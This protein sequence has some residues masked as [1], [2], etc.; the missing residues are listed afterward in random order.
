MNKVNTGTKFNSIT[1]KITNNVKIETIR[2]H[3]YIVIVMIIIIVG[4]IAYGLYYY[5]SNKI[6]YAYKSN[7]SYY[8]DNL[9]DYEPIFHY[10][11][12]NL[13]EC[14]NR[15]EQDILCTGITYNN[16]TQE[17]IGTAGIGVVRQEDA[18]LT[19]WVKQSTNLNVN[20]DFTKSIVLG[21]TDGPEIIPAKNITQPHIAGSFCLSFNLCIRDYHHNYGHWR[22]IL[23]KGTPPSQSNAYD[24]NTWERLVRDIPKQFIGIWLAPFNNNIRIAIS[25]VVISQTAKNY[26]D[27]ANVQ[28]CNFDSCYISDV[29]KISNADTVL[30]AVPQKIIKNI[31]FIEH[32]ISSVPLNREAN[33]II[34]VFSNNIELYQDGKLVKTAVLEGA[35]EFNSENMFVMQPNSINGYISNVIYYPAYLTLVDIS[36]IQNIPASSNTSNTSS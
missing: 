18:K 13:A 30:S 26:Y 15:C 3:P 14:V 23:H 21:W 19:S 10:N 17:C 32:D 35:P 33:Y 31:E 24:Y 16:E 36:K 20:N 2:D 7:S 6:D 34:N 22:H 8:G 9:L 27:H 12:N 5:F 11:T 29:D 1:N 25:T 28:I 4:F